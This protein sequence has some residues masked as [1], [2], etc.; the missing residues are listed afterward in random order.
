MGEETEPGTPRALVRPCTPAALHAFVREYLDVVV[1]TK[2]LIAGHASPFDYL[3]HAFEETEIPR[4]CVVWANRGGGKT[5]LA[6]V[7][8]L[9][10]LVFKDGIEIRILGGSLEQS[11]RMHTHLRALFEREPFAS[12]I[13][14]R[15]TDTKLRLT[16]GSEVQ[17]LAQ[18]QTSVRGTRVQKLRC[19][20]VELFDERVWD[21]AQLVTREKVCGPAD[22]PVFVPGSIECLSTMHVPYG[23]MHKLV[24][25]AGGHGPAFRHEHADGSPVDAT[26]RLFRW[27]VLDVL[28]ACG[29]EH[30]CDACPLELE[31]AGR[32][33]L[34][35]EGDAG[36]VSIGDAVRLKRRV[37]KSMWD[38]EMLCLRPHR[39]D[40]VLPEF[41]VSTHVI[42]RAPDEPAPGSP[43]GGWV[44]I[45]GMDFGIRA[46]TVVLWAAVDAE[47]VVRVLGEHAAAGVTL[48]RHAEAM[49]ESPWPAPAW[50]GVDPAGRQRS[51]QTGIS[52]AQA[53][54]K[55]GFTIRDRR[56]GVEQGL[57]LLRA[58]LSPAAG[59]PTLYIHRRC[60][61][62]I[63]SLEKYR[64]PSDRPE[65]LEPVKDG[66]DHAVDALRYMIQNLDAP[67][68]TKR[69]AYA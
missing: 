12:M 23:I 42:E 62:L 57:E 40:C 31:C 63:E 45:G 14:G 17:L 11:R 7:A 25:E 30:Q 59:P 10:D 50:L 38:T 8:T 66:S 47:G 4:D 24:K 39:S 29:D 53:M 9:L 13:E 37:G 69:G 26:R 61:K 5:F 1:P 18:S 58:R 32:A 33:K 55:L 34:R 51:N 15:V 44:W 64:Y 19:D 28:G 22:D 16:N 65:S 6:A 21:A 43:G 54:R 36:H 27:G 41:D 3:W 60:E 2:P 67:Y 56:M 52:D 68:E 49:R 46:P 20:E 48:E 35:D